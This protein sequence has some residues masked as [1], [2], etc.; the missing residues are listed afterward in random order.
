[1]HLCL[2]SGAMYN[3]YMIIVFLIC[4]ILVGGVINI[5]ADHLPVDRSIVH[6]YCPAC[7]A[8][9]PVLE[10]FGIPSVLFKRTECS[11]CGAGRGLRPIIVEL[12][13]GAAAAAAFLFS[14]DVFT[15][16]SA[17]LI[18]S[19]FLL[20]TVIDLEHRLILH[21][22]T[23][24]SA[25]LMA[26]MGL[27]GWIDPDRGVLSTLLGGMAGFGSVYLLYLLGIVFSRAM[28]KKQ[29]AEVEEV[30]F[31]FGDVTLSGVIGLIVGFPGVVVAIFFGIMAAGIFSL[32]Y[33]VLMMLRRRY[34]AFMP[35]P[36]GPFLILG[37]L[38]VYL[39]WIFPGF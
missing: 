11:Y 29:G 37:A 36:Y 31:G 26:V 4:G 20:I 30:A 25:I 5:L 28:A 8:P 21:M 17:Y 32:G 14:P 34:N 16:L 23:G 10:W 12:V 22:V 33:L 39:R 15:F 27:L 19:I 35:I 2:F 38:F 24:P 7:T 1:M 13:S 3:A 18:F 6:P 9:R